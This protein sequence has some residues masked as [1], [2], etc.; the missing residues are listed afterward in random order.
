M[1]AVDEPTTSGLQ[2][3]DITPDVRLAISQNQHSLNFFTNFIKSTCFVHKQSKHYSL[4][5]VSYFGIKKNSKL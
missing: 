5:L 4:I 3:A 1:A 2:K